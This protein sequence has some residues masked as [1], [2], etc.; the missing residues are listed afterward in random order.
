MSYEGF[1]IYLVFL[2]I[3][4]PHWK[5]PTEIIFRFLPF[6]V[7]LFCFCLGGFIF[8]RIKSQDSSTRVIQNKWTDNRAAKLLDR[9]IVKQPVRPM[10]RLKDRGINGQMEGK[11]A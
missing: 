2:F 5:V 1:L 7:F 4:P 9:Q 8:L 3:T 11:K 6:T 10:D